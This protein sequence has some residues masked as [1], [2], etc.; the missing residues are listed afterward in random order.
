MPSAPRFRSNASA[1]CRGVA[2]LAAVALFVAT[3]LLWAAIL[4]T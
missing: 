4:S 2:E 1:L 3:V